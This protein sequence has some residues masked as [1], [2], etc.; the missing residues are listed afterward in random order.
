MADE[1]GQVKCGFIDRGGKFV[2]PPATPRPSGP[3]GVAWSKA[4]AACAFDA[5]GRDITP[6]GRDFVGSPP[7]AWCALGRSQ[8]GLYGYRRQKGGRGAPLRQRQRLPRGHG[9]GLDRRQIRL[10]RP[11]GRLAVPAEYDTAEDFSDGLAPGQGGERRRFIDKTGRTVLEARWERV[12]AFGDGLAAA[13][14]DK[15][16]GYVDKPENGSSRPASPTP[17]LLNGLA[18]VS[19]GRRSAWIDRQGRA[20]WQDAP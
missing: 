9:A 3:G 5:A 14:E 4:K 12:T 19:E 7:K 1:W 6:C 15:L 16:W 20:V 18:A 11:P 13:K 17:G 2:V 8:A 10:H